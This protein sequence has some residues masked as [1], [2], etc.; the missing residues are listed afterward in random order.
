MKIGYIGLGKMGKNMVLNLLE[1]GIKVV[2]WNRSPEPLDE[3]VKA[4]AIK[5]KSIEDLVVNLDSSGPLDHQND[6]HGRIIW[7]MLT[8]GEVVDEYLDKLIK[9]L[10][11]G[12][13]IIDGGNSYFKDTLR[14]GENLKKLGIR[15]MD[16]GTSGGP[17][18]AREGACLMIGGDKKDFQE[19][20]P[21]VKA[22]SAK[23]AYGHF[24]KVGAG[25][26][27]KMVHNGIEYGMMESIA[28]G[29]AILENSQF[30]LDLREVF[31]VYNSRSVVESRLVGWLLDA[32]RD[33]PKLKD[34]SS[35]IHSTGEG[36]WTIKT[37]K[38]MGIDIPVIEDSFKV[39][40]NSS[41]DKENSPTGFRNKSVSAMRGKFGQHS[42]KKS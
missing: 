37:A 16:I 7:L 8:A 41:K 10:D 19:I 15:F 36:E 22:A 3:V 32:F 12:D 11:K 24:G 9:L 42:V 18:G 13:L 39:R 20:L 29:A 26:F 38:E 5:A 21:L 40:K 28:E 33:D 2:A 25:H 17:S 30:N 35:E 4:G 31:R 27:V 34:I 14:R 1:K 6:R 23:D